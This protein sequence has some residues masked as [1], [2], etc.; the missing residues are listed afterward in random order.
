MTELN[1]LIHVSCLG[2]YLVQALKNWN[3][4][5]SSLIMSLLN[6]KGKG[7]PQFFCSKFILK[8]DWYYQQLQSEGLGAR[9]L[10]L[11]LF[12]SEHVLPI[13]RA[14]WNLFLEFLS[15]PL[16]CIF[17]EKLINWLYNL[18][19]SCGLLGTTIIITFSSDTS[20]NS[21]PFNVLSLLLCSLPSS[22][23][24]YFPIGHNY[25]WLSWS[26]SWK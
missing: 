21:Y 11:V 26:F 16:V 25:F 6:Y 3:Q 24:V 23:C 13:R 5:V 10:W 14:H 9:C 22:L 20:K 18:W 8:T 19:H 1:E 12:I 2:E 15:I 17:H 4:L 7:S